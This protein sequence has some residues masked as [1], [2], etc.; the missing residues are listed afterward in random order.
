MIDSRANKPVGPRMTLM[1]RGDGDKASNPVSSDSQPAWPDTGHLS[2]F[3]AKYIGITKNF[4]D[5]WMNDMDPGYPRSSPPC[6]L[7]QT[8]QLSSNWTF[9]LQYLLARSDIL[10]LPFW[11]DSERDWFY[12]VTVIGITKPKMARV[13]NYNKKSYSN[14]DSLSNKLYFYWIFSIENSLLSD[15]INSLR[16]LFT[17]IGPNNNSL[18]CPD[19]ADHFASLSD[20]EILQFCIV[21]LWKDCLLCV[22]YRCHFGKIRIMKDHADTHLRSIS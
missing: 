15:Q 16:S 8:S 17:Q 3:I 6:A 2:E 14:P 10:W 20:D 22:C 18:H 4:T 13:Q 19:P 7:A 11:T 21:M 9:N 1:S 12:L 5:I